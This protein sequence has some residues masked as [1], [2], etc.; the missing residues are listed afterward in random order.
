MPQP[1]GGRRVGSGRPHR[2][3]CRISASILR[4]VYLELVRQEKLTGLYRCQ[5]VAQIVTAHLVGGIVSR[6]L[7]DVGFRHGRN[8]AN[9]QEPGASCGLRPRSSAFL[10][11]PWPR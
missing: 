3:T 9:G 4:P 11:E 7:A 5:I 10:W 8:G 2:D 1:H 6:E